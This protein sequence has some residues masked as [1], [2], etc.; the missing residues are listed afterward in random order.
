[1]REKKIIKTQEEGKPS[2]GSA[3]AVTVSHVLS[4]GARASVAEQKASRKLRIAARK[5][6]SLRQ[7]R[8]L[9]ETQQSNERDR[10]LSDESQQAGGEDQ[11]VVLAEEEEDS[12]AYYEK[13]VVLSDQEKE[14]STI[15]MTSPHPSATPEGSDNDEMTQQQEEKQDAEDEAKL[16]LLRKRRVLSE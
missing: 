6:E 5:K 10:R 14:D 2:R 16:K 12:E 11:P 1:M 13:S 3:T 15:K 7:A 4:A 9:Y 8:E